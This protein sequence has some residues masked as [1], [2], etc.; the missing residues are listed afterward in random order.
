LAMS[1]IT[2]GNTI[3]IILEVLMYG[4]ICFLFGRVLVLIL[5]F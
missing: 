1:Y 5:P 3:L 2:R 4:I